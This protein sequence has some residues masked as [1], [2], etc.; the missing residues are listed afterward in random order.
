LLTKRHSPLT[1]FNAAALAVSALLLLAPS[2]SAQTQAKLDSDDRKFIQEEAANGAALVRIAKLG[3]KQAERADIKAYAQMIVADHTNAN[4]ELQRLARSKG[5]ELNA[6]VSRKH[7]RSYKKL[8]AERG[9]EFDREF[10]AMIAKGHER[11]LENYEDAAEDAEDREVKMWATQ[12]VPVL[13]S[14]LDSAE[15][16][17]SGSMMR[18]GGMVTTSRDNSD[19]TMRDRDAM[20][21]DTRARTMRDRNAADYGT[22]AHSTAHGSMSR[23]SAD[24]DNTTRTMRGQEVKSLTPL[25]QGNSKTDIDTTAQIRKA[26]LDLDDISVNAQ[27]VKIITKDGRVTLRGRVNSENEKRLIAD[28]AHR[29]AG[30]VDNQL[31][32]RGKEPTQ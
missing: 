28:I 11:C 31:E 3:A 8:A 20:A 10:L 14:H 1:L 27:N 21:R 13:Q 26:I 25:D 7:Q 6:D 22:P 16:L 32:V 15:S 5:V 24:P 19:R 4:T 30:L 2:V 17:S 9:E 29:T 23:D 18:S 12:R